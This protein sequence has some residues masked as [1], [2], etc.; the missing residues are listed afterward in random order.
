MRVAQRLREL[1][2]GSIPRGRRPSTR[3]NP[4]G[5]TGREVEVLALLAA[6]HSNAEIAGRLYLST[7]TV[8]HHV[9]RVL[10]KLGCATRH[11]AAER[12][13]ALGVVPPT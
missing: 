5:L 4:A 9:S 6:G 12:A 13:T 11:Q 3:A 8:E 10:A 2:T 7:K 1:G